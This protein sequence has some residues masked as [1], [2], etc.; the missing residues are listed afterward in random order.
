MKI[1]AGETY[2][3]KNGMPLYCSGKIM[4]SDDPSELGRYRVTC[5]ADSQVFAMTKKGRCISDDRF[6]IVAPL[7]WLMALEMV[8]KGQI[9]G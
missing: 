2:W 8:C 3:A 5:L 9:D 1:R 4:Y 6:S 7:H